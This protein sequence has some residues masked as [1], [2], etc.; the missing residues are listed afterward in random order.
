MKT[1]FNFVVR[2]NALSLL[3]YTNIRVSIPVHGGQSSRLVTNGVYSGCVLCAVFTHRRS[4]LISLCTKY[5]T[6][7]LF[8]VYIHAM[9]FFR[10]IISL[11]SYQQKPNRLQPTYF[12][13]NHTVTI[14]MHCHLKAVLRRI[15]RSPL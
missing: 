3:S 7:I 13:Y 15:S 12:M 14:G 10:G 9:S 8:S 2:K 5:N 6:F 4:F 11:L 1:Q